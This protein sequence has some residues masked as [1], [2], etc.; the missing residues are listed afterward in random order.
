MFMLRWYQTLFI[1]TAALAGCAPTVCGPGTKL[2]Q[3]A[4]GVECV[5]AD[6]PANGDVSCDVDAGMV[7]IVGGKCES[8]VQCDPGSTTYDPTT[9]ICVGSG[10]Q[11]SLCPVCPPPGTGQICITG[12]VVDFE[13]GQHVMPGGRPLRFAA[14]EPLAF[15]A[16]PGS[17]PLAED[18]SSTKA[19][20]TLTLPA[21]SSGLV[22]IAVSDPV[23]GAPM[24]MLP[25]AL[26]GVGAPVTAGNVYHVD[27]IL[28]TRKRLADWSTQS[29]EDFTG[30]GAFVGCYYA[31]PPAAPTN[32][33]FDETM[34][35]SGVKLL[36]NQSPPASARYLGSN[37]DIDTALTATGSLGCAVA[38]ADG[39]QTFGGQAGAGTSPMVQKLE[40]QP[41]GTAPGALFL[42]RFH[43]CDNNPT[44]PACQ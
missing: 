20:F 44:A 43:S 33:I 3:T 32:E 6:G 27:G 31:D 22:A 29:G 26:G 24:G 37:R 35:V 16:D 21:P 8:R 41:G 5:P 13:T 23:N 12:G 34:P 40:A 10:T 39:I 18:P 7:E 17:A 15:L 28:A 25:L 1:I 9:G 2:L 14:F 36:E 19:C 38:T 30:K 11:N 42:S 4:D